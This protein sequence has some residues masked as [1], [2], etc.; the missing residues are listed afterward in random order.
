M[1]FSKKIILAAAVAICSAA[2]AFSLEVSVISVKGKVETMKN[3]AWVKLEPGA[4]LNEGSVIQTGYKSEVE[5][6]VGNATMNVAPLSRMTVAQ[7]AEVK[8]DEKTTKEVSN[9]KLE[10][11]SVRSKA[12][13]TDTRKVGHTVT[14]AVATASVRG[15]DFEVKNGYR[16]TQVSAY[17]GLVA[18]W[19]SPDIT[20]PAASTESEEVA[21]EEK[22]EEKEAKAEEKA[23]AKETKAEEKAEAKEAKAEAKAS[24]TNDT[25]VSAQAISDLA[26][27]GAATVGI[28]QKAVFSSDGSSKNTQSTAQERTRKLEAA[29]TT[30]ETAS[31]VNDVVTPTSD[32]VVQTGNLNITLEW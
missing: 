1:K 21:E 13:H 20:K 22:T 18:V 28:G 32:S 8:V 23:E 26:P 15:T 19:A 3:S 16:S 17:E 25:G 10:T 14:G 5:L 6:K 31:T 29:A 30:V 12:R 4:I 2:C 7:I 11:G 24:R 27:V 9:F